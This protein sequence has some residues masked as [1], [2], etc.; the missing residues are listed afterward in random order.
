MPKPQGYP[1]NRGSRAKWRPLPSQ[2]QSENGAA[3]NTSHFNFDHPTICTPADAQATRISSKPR[4]LATVHEAAASPFPIPVRK[5]RSLKVATSRERPR[6]TPGKEG[7]VLQLPRPRLPT[8]PESTR[9]LHKQGGRGYRRARRQQHAIVNDGF[10]G[11]IP[12]AVLS[13]EAWCV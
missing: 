5:R 4:T 12:G 10:R 2:S 8:R 9:P 6:R 7:Q 13:P 3:G 1:A 11:W